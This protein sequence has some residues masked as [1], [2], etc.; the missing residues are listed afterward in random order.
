MVPQNTGAFHG[1]SEARLLTAHPET[2]L[3][4]ELGAQLRRPAH[5]HRG[6]GGPPQELQT[7]EM[8]PG[9]LR[10]PP[11]DNPPDEPC[12]PPELFPVHDETELAG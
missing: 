1:S 11:P 2:P 7:Q 10:F 3:I 12:V 5:T 6:L 4:H 9:T 8:N